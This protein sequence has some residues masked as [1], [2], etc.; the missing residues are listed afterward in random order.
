MTDLL[1]LILI[2]S[3][4]SVGIYIATQWDGSE[5]F[6]LAHQHRARYSAKPDNP[7]ILWWVRYYLARVI[8]FYWTKPIYSCLPCMGSVHS[9]YVVV[10]FGSLW[11]WPVVAVAT[12]GV[13]YL[14]TIWWSK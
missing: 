11:M 13:N 4:C 3:A 1:C 2:S 6:D 12:V 8:P 7:M 14:I 9:L 5:G 10:L